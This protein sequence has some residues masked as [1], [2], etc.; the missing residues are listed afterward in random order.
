MFRRTAKPYGAPR[1]PRVW[2]WLRSFA[3]GSV[4]LS[5]AVVGLYRGQINFRRSLTL[6]ADNA[7]FCFW[8]YVL[9]IGGLGLFVLYLAITEFKEWRRL[10]R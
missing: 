3:I 10:R 6:T 1:I 8:L 4:L 2:D 9:L 7:P 5:F